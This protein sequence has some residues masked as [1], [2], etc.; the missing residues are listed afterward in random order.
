MTAAPVRRAG[1]ARSAADEDEDLS[2]IAVGAVLLT[3]AL[4]FAFV[5]VAMS[6]STG[7]VSGVADM[8]GGIFAADK[9][10]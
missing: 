2:P 4:M 5:S 1:A 8:V 7:N 6:L 9:F 3:V 10:K